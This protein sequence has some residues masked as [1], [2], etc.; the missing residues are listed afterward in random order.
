MNSDPAAYGRIL[1]AARDAEG[2]LVAF[3]RD[4]IR[5]PG[6]SGTEQR[7]ADRLIAE[8][9]TLGYD[10]VERDGMGN[11]LG[12]MEPAGGSRKPHD[13]QVPILAFDAHI[14]TVGVGAREA[15]T[16]D[17]FDGAEDEQTV[18]GRGASDQKGGLASM[19]YA[20]GLVKKL[21]LNRDCAVLAVGSVQEEDCEGLC[22]QYIVE[23]DGIRPRLVVS[24]EPSSCTVTRGQRGRMEIRVVTRG[25]SCHGSAPERGENAVYKMAPI[26]IELQDLAGRLGRHEVLGA[27]TLTVS[28]IFFTSPSRCAVADSCTISIDRRLTLGETAAAALEEVRAL[29]S[30]RAARAEVDMYRYETP[31]YTGSV[32]PTDAYFPPWLLEESHEAVRLLVDAHRSL[33]SQEPVVG[34]WT[35]STNGVSITGRYG[36]PTV[37]YGPGHEDQAHAPDERTWKRELIRACALYAGTAA[38]ASETWRKT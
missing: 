36:I 26:L 13:G 7:V 8:M 11:V 19:V 10:R 22:W 6:T 32:F 12:T 31:S 21:G 28:E 15:W 25:K 20:G 16:V 29:A 33:F 27:G 9:S 18:W 1:D 34:T 14:D 17:P 4:L 23:R 5:I 24:T 38:L 35:F 30:V 3:L 2:P 37:G